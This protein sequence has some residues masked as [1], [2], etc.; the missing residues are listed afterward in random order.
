M[1]KQSGKTQA[2]IAAIVGYSQATISKEYRN[3]CY[4]LD[5]QYDGR[6]E[7]RSEYSNYYYSC[8]CVFNE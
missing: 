4:N 7:V 6:V 1:L 8:R 5:I 3:M 2:D